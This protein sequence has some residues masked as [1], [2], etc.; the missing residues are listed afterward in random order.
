MLVINICVGF[1]RLL[2]VR[3]LAVGAGC[4]VLLLVDAEAGHLLREGLK[5]K[6]EKKRLVSALLSSFVTF[7][8]LLNIT[9]SQCI[10]VR[11]S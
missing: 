5:E 4:L 2:G 3:G 8:G 6:E 7:E 11:S 1:L 10:S 9:G